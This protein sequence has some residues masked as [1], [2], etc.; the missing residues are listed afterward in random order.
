M[1][2]ALIALI[3]IVL[4]RKNF[5]DNKVIQSI[6]SV[7]CNLVYYLTQYLI[8]SPVGF[9]LN[10]IKIL[11]VYI[12]DDV[13]HG[14]HIYKREKFENEDEGNLPDPSPDDTCPTENRL[15]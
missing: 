7:I 15:F 4:L 12:K 10:I 8:I 2:I 3:A 11:T 5:R 13:V 6:T 1:K 9:A 14:K